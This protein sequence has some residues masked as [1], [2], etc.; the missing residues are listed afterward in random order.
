M[1][2]WTYAAPDEIASSHESRLFMINWGAAQMRWGYQRDLRRAI[3]RHLKEL[4][5]R[6]DIFLP[7]LHYLAAGS[8]LDSASYIKEHGWL[9]YSGI[10]HYPGELR[11]PLYS[12]WCS[13]GLRTDFG[14]GPF[15]SRYYFC[16]QCVEEDLDVRGFSY[17]R[18][19]HQ[20]LGVD[21]CARHRIRLSATDIDSERLLLPHMYLGEETNANAELAA[22]SADHPAIGRYERIAAGL[23]KRDRSTSQEVAW[24]VFD[25]RCQELDLLREGVRTT[26]ALRERI[27]SEFP[28]GWLNQHFISN[29]DAAS[30]NHPDWW[31]RWFAEFVLVLAAMFDSAEE[32]LGRFSGEHGQASP[33]NDRERY[34]DMS[35]LR[36]NYQ[37]GY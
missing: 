3:R 35:I 24:R 31:P 9:A 28:A 14:L 22:C 6:H 37:F 1:L 21:R 34:W 12:E 7:T 20:V 30:I 13:K 36:P 11:S 15:D 33:I 16:R 19:I 18:R 5:H 4:D 2:T 23:L 25:E 32:A 17:W 10:V 26:A 8:G 29:G 27:V